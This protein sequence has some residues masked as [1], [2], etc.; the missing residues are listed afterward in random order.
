MAVKADRTTAETTKEKGETM[1]ASFSEFVGLLR[2]MARTDRID[3]YAVPVFLSAMGLI[4]DACLAGFL[5]A[6]VE[7]LVGE[8][9]HHHLHPHYRH[10]HPVFCILK[11]GYPCGI[12]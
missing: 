12:W 6:L 7:D 3:E 11:L 8:E 10:H 4:A 2:E 5:M 1:D 9:E